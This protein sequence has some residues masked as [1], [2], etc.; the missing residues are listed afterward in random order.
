MESKKLLVSEASKEKVFG[1]ATAVADFCDRV[2]CNHCP[3]AGYH[4]HAICVA[5]LALVA[6]KWR[7][8]LNEFGK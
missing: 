7:V 3:M 1:K 8:D 6:E 5:M 2:G 4:R